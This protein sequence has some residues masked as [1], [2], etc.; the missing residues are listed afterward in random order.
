MAAAVFGDPSFVTYVD[1]TPQTRFGLLN[2]G[3]IDMLAARTTHTM[4]RDTFEVGH[5]K[6]ELL[7]FCWIF[8]IIQN[9]TAPRQGF[10]SLCLICSVECDSVE[11]HPFW[12]ALTI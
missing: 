4:E 1:V 10:R 6:L 8:L 11:S 12:N 3:R 5:A 9:R 2:D 7:L